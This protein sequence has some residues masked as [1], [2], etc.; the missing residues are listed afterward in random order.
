MNENVPDPTDCMIYGYGRASTQYQKLS[1]KAQETQ[2]TDAAVPQDDSQEQA[3][4]VEQRLQHGDIQGT[5]GGFFCDTVST[6]KME[7]TER[8]QFQLLRTKLHAGDRLIIV[9]FDRVC[10]TPLES[11]D[12]LE[13]VSKKGV[14]LH[15][16]R[17]G[18]MEL[19]FSSPLGNLLA[20]IL[21]VFARWERDM[22]GQ[23]TR[24]AIAYQKQRGS[25]SNGR[26]RIGFKR[27]LSKPDGRGRRSVVEYVRDEREWETIR[28]IYTRH[29]VGE[30]FQ[31]IS[32]DLRARNVA[33]AEGGVW[34]GMRVWRAWKLADKLMKNNQPL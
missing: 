13:F 21:A 29:S 22:I 6:R 16:L 27:K 3:E 34:Y 24:E 4:A 12:F 7:Y 33:T 20:G 15:I 26:P 1:L 32:D 25:Y 31:R 19:D 2:I 30:G 11:F 23:R 8:P 10:R 5:W 14:R 17:H 28:E 9:A 18:G